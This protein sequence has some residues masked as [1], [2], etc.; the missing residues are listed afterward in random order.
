MHP[1]LGAFMVIALIVP[2]QVRAWGSGQAACAT[3]RVS[4]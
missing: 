4:R 1:S 3:Q 2:G